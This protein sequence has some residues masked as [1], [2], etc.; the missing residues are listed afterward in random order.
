MEESQHP[1][2]TPVRVS[3][4]AVDAEASLVIVNHGGALRARMFELSPDG[5]RARADRFIAVNANTG[6]E[7]IFKINGIGCR[8]AGTMQWLDPRQ[9]VAIRFSSMAPRRREALEYLLDELEAQK[10][11][12]EQAKRLTQAA[13]KPTSPTA[14]MSAATADR[15]A[16]GIARILPMPTGLPG[17]Q[18]PSMAAPPPR[19][20]QLACPISTDTIQLPVTPSIKPPM[21]RSAP[22]A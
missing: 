13:G 17:H 20:A 21:G 7:V 2:G 14:R 18:S 4:Y 22:P 3:T 8:L 9:T 6:V 19:E 10:Q 5:C 15:P 11:A 16:P 12:E 1:V